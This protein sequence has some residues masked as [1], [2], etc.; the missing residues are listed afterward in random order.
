MIEIKSFLKTKGKFVPIREFNEVIVDP[1][2]IDGAITIVAGGR[3]LLTLGMWDYVD[4]LWTYIAAGV[5]DIGEG[6]AFSTYFPDQ[7][8]KLSFE[9]VSNSLVRV[10]VVC[11]QEA[12]LAIVD[13]SEFISSF[14]RAGE[15]FF[16]TMARLLP[17]DAEMYAKSIDLL[18]TCEM[19]ASST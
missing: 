14:V 11:N 16:S 10:T 12:S 17:S 2:Y 3:E 7:P 13:K 8:I 19:K 6:K 18:V 1:N 4:Q 9:P 5:I 15:E